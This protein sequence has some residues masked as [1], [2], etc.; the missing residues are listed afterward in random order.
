M[1]RSGELWGSLRG[2][3]RNHPTF[4]QIKDLVGAAGLPVQKLAH[5]Q[6]KQSGG[7]SKGQLMDEI[8]GLI[9]ELDDERRDQFVAT[10][11]KELLRR[12]GHLRD[13]IEA[14]FRQHGWSIND[15]Q[16]VIPLVIDDSQTLEEAKASSETMLKKE[17]GFLF[18]PFRLFLTWYHKLNIRE[19]IVVAIIGFLGVC[20]LAS[21]NIIA[22]YIQSHAQQKKQISTTKREEN[23][24]ILRDLTVGGDIVG[25]DKIIVQTVP[26]SK[27]ENIHDQIKVSKVKIK[28][29]LEDLSYSLEDTRKEYLKE[30]DKVANDFNSR[31]M[32]RSGIFIR[33][34]MDLAIGMKER[35]EKS[36]IKARR[37]I[38]DITLDNFKATELKEI[39]EFT[40]ENQ[41]LVEI[42]RNK[43]PEIYKT[44]ENIVKSWERKALQTSELTK[45]FKL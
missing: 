18:N 44:F 27:T 39:P 36:I 11:T 42:E 28:R 40:E 21:S 41:A 20:V 15:T 7:A 31:N 5:L 10:C 25:R 9:N 1:K 26:I 38:Q 34:Q 32:L 16:E 22:A 24:T 14:I 4:A 37:D 12:Y 35:I 17:K 43:V 3:L 23:P 33:A 2:I 13:E 6:Q 45:D 29:I 19:K 8:D 30:S